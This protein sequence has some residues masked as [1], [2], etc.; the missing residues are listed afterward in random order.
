M[1]EPYYEDEKEVALWVA[2]ILIQEGYKTYF[3][4]GC[5]RDHLLG[6]K[7]KDYD[8]ATAAPPEEI[9]KIFPRAQ[10]VGASFGVFI[11]LKG[12]HSVEVASFRK[13]FGYSDGRRPDTI[14][15]GT[16]EEDSKRRD[17]TING[18][19]EDPET[20]E[21]IDYVSGQD[22]LNSK[23][24][25]A[26]GLPEDRLK[27]D[28]LRGLR[29]IRFAARFNFL[30]EEKTAEAISGHAHELKGVS[31]ER[32]GDELRMM[33]KHPNR[34]M[35]AWK[36]Q[37]LGLDASVFLEKTNKV[38]PRLLANLPQEIDFI[39]AL[40]GWLI[41]RCKSFKGDL[42]EYAS[43]WKEC[44][45][46]SNHEYYELNQIIELRGKIRKW[47]H[48]GVASQKRFAADP[49]FS[50]MMLILKSEVI[51]IWT[52]IQR[53]V[54]SLSKTGL[55]PVPLINGDILIQEGF[56]PS[57]KMGVLLDQVYDA[58]LEG[59]ITSQKEA[60]ELA[61]VIIKEIL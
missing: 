36:I 1:T 2:R 40:A 15:I 49:I 31:R 22:D 11:V 23:T 6:F 17:F 35:A 13:E 4:G 14:A 28:H 45:V 33:L 24:I 7:P 34:T 29:A 55:S 50:K 10:R 8:V 52:E 5:V 60:I 59:A 43:R 38:A 47:R 51:H 48:L 25:R 16:P 39:T 53:D 56:E 27:E 18:L 32:I 46:L 20:G 37:Y 41:D 54:N 58:Q 26:I 21:I 9:I 12:I 44:L 3:A 61:K 42:H 30:I 57:P 19:F